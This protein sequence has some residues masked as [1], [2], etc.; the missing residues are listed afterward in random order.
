M[1]VASHRLQV[2]ELNVFC[3]SVLLQTA[4]LSVLPAM[5]PEGD[6]KTANLITTYHLLDKRCTFSTAVSPSRTN[7]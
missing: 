4:L 7:A 5:C 3:I 1:N 2:S 6:D